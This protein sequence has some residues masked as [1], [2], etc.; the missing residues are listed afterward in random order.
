MSKPVEEL[1]NLGSAFAFLISCSVIP[2]TLFFIASLTIGSAAV[3]AINNNDAPIG[4]SF[5]P[6]AIPPAA[7][8]NP[9][10]AT[11]AIPIFAKAPPIPAPI[12]FGNIAPT[13]SAAIAARPM[14]ILVHGASDN[15]VPNFERLAP[16]AFQSIVS[17]NSFIAVPAEERI[18]LNLPSVN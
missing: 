11:F 4:P 17:T 5:I 1:K 14:P 13:P 7:A 2:N 6:L 9:C 12:R 3:T 18:S 10:V 8:G 16:I 15:I